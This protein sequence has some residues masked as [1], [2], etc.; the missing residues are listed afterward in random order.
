MV[1][2]DGRMFEK[3]DGNLY[4]ELLN[5]QIAWHGRFAVDR[6]CGE[7]RRRIDEADNARLRVH[8]TRAAAELQLHEPHHINVDEDAAP[9]Q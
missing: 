9:D 5:P 3:E 6:G 7:R 8:G 1:I 2:R 4:S